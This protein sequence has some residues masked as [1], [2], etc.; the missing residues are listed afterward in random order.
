M[1]IVKTGDDFRIDIRRL[2]RMSRSRGPPILR[3]CQVSP[4]ST[5]SQKHVQLRDGCLWNSRDSGKEAAKVSI[6]PRALLAVKVLQG[7]IREGQGSA[8][9]EKQQNSTIYR[10]YSAKESRIEKTEPNCHEPCRKRRPSS[11]HLCALNC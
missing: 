2:G 8:K 6:Y 1:A 3:S 11:R 5:R 4:H 9:R 7:A 10:H